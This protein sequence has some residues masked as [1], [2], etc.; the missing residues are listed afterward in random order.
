ML[1]SWPVLAVLLALLIH[2][3][4]YYYVLLVL[5]FLCLQFGYAVVQVWQQRPRR[6]AR[7]AL[8]AL[9]ALAVTES[10]LGVAASLRAAR[11]TTPYATL[12]ARLSQA[13]APGARVLLAE[14]YWL[15][16][17]NHE[18]RSI[19]LAFLLSDPRYF[20]Q[21][22]AIREVLR[23]LD[24]DYVVTEER[25]LDIYGRDPDD[26]SENALDWKALDDYLRAQC[27]RVA[28]ALNT[29]DYGEVKVYACAAPAVTDP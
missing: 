7:L 23:D 16:L 26:L 18:A 27:P 13:I 1:L 22:P 6:W 14:P 8:G 29:P 11:S 15:G 24:P 2:Y 28:A 3:K 17:A 19:Q 12:S 4:R 21:P 25:L 10:A 5:P 9:L 20:A